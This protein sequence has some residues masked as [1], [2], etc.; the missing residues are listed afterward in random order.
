MTICT[1]CNGDIGDKYCGNCGQAAMLKRIDKHY[2]SHEVQHLLHFERGL[3]YTVKQLLLR[4][5]LTV[6]EF[7]DQNRSKHMKP[8]P[9]LI[10]TSVLYTVVAHFFHADQIYNE[11]EKILLES[12]AVGDIQHWVQTHYGYANILMGIFIAICVRLF[13]RKYKYNFFEITVLMCF[14]MGQG[15]L[16]L[17]VEALFVGLLTKQAFILILTVISFIYPTWAIGQFFDKGKISS[18]AKALF[19]YLLGYLLFYIIIIIVGMGVDVLIA[20]VK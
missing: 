11:R 16:L 17:T 13:F 2:I 12:S 10:L 6:R 5:G 15:M 20:L 18:Y 14:V 19:A 4:P 1:N 8:F 3:L 9:F 7:I